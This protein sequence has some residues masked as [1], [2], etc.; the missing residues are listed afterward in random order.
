[1]QLKLDRFKKDLSELFDKSDYWCYIL[2]NAPVIN[3]ETFNRLSEDK[4]FKEI[5]WHLKK[6]S[7]DETAKML[8]EYEEMKCRDEQSRLDARYEKGME[9]GKQETALRMIE[10][11][12][13]ISSISEFTGLSKKEIKLDV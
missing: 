10:K 5:M 6:L 11:N 12:L 2:K 9:K 7:K 3:K 8:E 4:E 13:N 1:M